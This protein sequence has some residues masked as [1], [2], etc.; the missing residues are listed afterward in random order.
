MSGRLDRL[1]ARL[2]PVPG[3]ARAH[4][5]RNG[6]ITLG[7][8]IGVLAL[9]FAVSLVPRGTSVFAQRMGTGAQADQYAAAA[10]ASGTISSA[11]VFAKRRPLSER[12]MTSRTS[13]PAS[14]F[15]TATQR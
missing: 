8:L 3:R 13:A 6:V 2:E 7:V 11:G 9:V 10:A 12:R 1:R 14:S 4:P 5:W 15:R